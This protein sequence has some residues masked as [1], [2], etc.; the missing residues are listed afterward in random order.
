MA[1][2]KGLRPDP[3]FVADHTALDALSSV[4]APWGKEIEWWGTGEE[5]LDWLIRSGL[6]EKEVADR[7]QETSTAKE[8]E[9]LAV[10]AKELREHFR[11][12]ICR[13]AGARLPD[14]ELSALNHLNSLLIQDT[15]YVQATTDGEGHAQL[16]WFRQWNT[17]SQVLLPLATVMVELLC[18]PQLERVRN[19]EGPTCTLWFL[20]ISKN[21]KRRWC[22]MSVCGNRAKAAAHRAR[23]KA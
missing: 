20:D 14:T 6:I 3:F 15:R 1:E 13:Y 22:T 23:K 10:T 21:Q 7:F 5:V 12:L 9:A 19:C 18:S 11:E 17:V 2:K 8:L 16:S 4:C